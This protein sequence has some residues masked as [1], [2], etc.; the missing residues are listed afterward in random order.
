M[1]PKTR[2]RYLIAE[3]RKRKGELLELMSNCEQ[4]MQELKALIGKNSSFRE[5]SRNP[6]K[7][8]WDAYKVGRAD[9][10]SPCGKITFCLVRK[11]A[12]SNLV[13]GTNS[14]LPVSW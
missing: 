14:L 8:L 11:T 12:N 3:E 6:A 4:T 10:D 7:R 9:L 2:T 5:D 13:I 1:T